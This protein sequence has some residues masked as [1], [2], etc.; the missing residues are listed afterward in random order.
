[1][2]KHT[3]DFNMTFEHATETANC[4]SKGI[5]KVDGSDRTCYPWYWRKEY[6]TAIRGEPLNPDYPELC[7]AATNKFDPRVVKGE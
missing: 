7:W 4:W 5:S 2:N 3:T 6:N 1:M